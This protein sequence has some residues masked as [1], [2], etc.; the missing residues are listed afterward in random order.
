MKK[1]LTN[2]LGSLAKLMTSQASRTT[3]DASPM[4]EMTLGRG[5]A[6]SAASG[7]GGSMRACVAIWS[8]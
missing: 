7:E 2:S 3:T 4:I 8:P 6:R 5:R 1:T